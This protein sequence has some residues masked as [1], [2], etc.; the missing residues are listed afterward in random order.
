MSEALNPNSTG[1]LFLDNLG[2]NSAALLL[3]RLAKMKAGNGLVIADPG[4][5]LKHVMFPIS[6][7]ISAVTRMQDGTDVEVTLIGRE[8]L[9]GFQLALGHDTSA[10]AA[11]VQIPDSMLWM[12]A[13]AFRTCLRADPE[14]N[15]RVLDFAMVNLENIAQFSGCNRLHPINERLARWLLMAHDRVMGDELMLT[16]EFLAT[17]LGV[18]RPAVSL[19]ASALDQAGVIL[20]RYGRI[21]IVNRGGL[22]LASCECYMAANNAIERLLGYSIRKRV[23]LSGQAV[24]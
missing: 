16:H 13:A 22:E 17:M 7:V 8:G 3:P 19:A 15:Q 20:Y 23:P 4:V 1:N 12:T 10:A 14:L 11:M 6:S 24:A 9:Y 2:L 5:P 21:L 18:R